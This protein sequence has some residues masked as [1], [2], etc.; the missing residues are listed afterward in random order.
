MEFEQLPI[1][2]ILNI[3]IQLNIPDISAIICTNKFLYRTLTSDTAFKR[4][5]QNDFNHL[6][7][8]TFDLEKDWIYNYKYTQYRN[9]IKHALSEKYPDKIIFLNICKIVVKNLDLFRN[10]LGYDF[11]L[12]IFQKIHSCWN[13]EQYYEFKEYIYIKF[14]EMIQITKMI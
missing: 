5:Y 4:L 6:T 10:K 3:F 9:K 2:I 13:S 14:L 8:K 1:D 7:N 11:R 12:V